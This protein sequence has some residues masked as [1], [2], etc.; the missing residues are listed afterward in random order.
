MKFFD[1]VSHATFTRCAEKAGFDTHYACCLMGSWSAYRI[2][3]VDE[4]RKLDD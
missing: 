4:A 3:L 2:M 1:N